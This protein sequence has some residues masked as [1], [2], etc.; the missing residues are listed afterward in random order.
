MSMRTIATK[1][2][3]SDASSITF[4]S[5]PQNYKDLVLI[6]STRASEGVT[7][8]FISAQFNNNTGNVYGNVYL[9]GGNTTAS[10]AY[11]SFGAIRE[12]LALS[13]TRS[14]VKPNMT[15]NAYTTIFSYSDTDKF[16]HTLTETNDTSQFYYGITAGVF[17]STSAVTSITV[18][19]DT[20][21]LA[22][23]T[24]VTLMGVTA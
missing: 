20:G 12:Y 8:R 17:Q 3:T 6:T 14:A 19:H 23:G 22:A 24:I 1:T 13:I 5:I 10:P 9:F 2:L 18:K 11:S 7:A 4:N 15:N 21:V 16:K